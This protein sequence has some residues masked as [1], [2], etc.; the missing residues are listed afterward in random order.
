[1]RGSASRSDQENCGAGRRISAFPRR[2]VFLQV[3][4][5]AI[6]IGLIPQSGP[7]IL[8]VTLFAH[9]EV[10]LSILLANSI[11]QEGHAGLPLLAESRSSFFRMKAIS[12]IIGIF[13]GLLGYFL[14]F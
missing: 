3:L 13:V 10:P 7:H 1:V 5:L 12:A 2:A 14:E 8:F 9:G 4:G 11:V 6:L